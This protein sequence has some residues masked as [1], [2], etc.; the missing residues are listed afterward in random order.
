MAWAESQASLCPVGYNPVSDCGML[1]GLSN[2]VHATPKSWFSGNL[3]MRLAIC[4]PEKGVE[5]SLVGG[6][7]AWK[8]RKVRGLLILPTALFRVHHSSF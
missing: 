1:A 4:T 6:A 8:H 2:V 5:T 3:H 7:Q